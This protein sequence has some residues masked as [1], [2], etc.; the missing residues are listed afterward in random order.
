VD[1]GYLGIIKYNQCKD[2]AMSHK[3]TKNNRL[4]ETKKYENK[5]MI[6]ERIKVEHSLIGGM[7]RYRILSNRL[8]IHLIDLYYDIRHC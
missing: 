5:R 4:T 8:R 6:S 7:K 1:L 3:K 2:I